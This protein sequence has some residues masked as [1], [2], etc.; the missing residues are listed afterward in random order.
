M[1]LDHQGYQVF[2][3]HC[4]F[5]VVPVLDPQIIYMAYLGGTR[6]TETDLRVVRIRKQL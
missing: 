2:T 6:L 3:F 4:L 5:Y 1:I